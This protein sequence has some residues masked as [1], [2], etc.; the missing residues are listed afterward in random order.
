MLDIIPERNMD[1]KAEA[2]A[3]LSA[4]IEE[5]QLAPSTVGRLIAKDPNFME[6]LADPDKDITTTTLD[7]IWRFIMRKR[8]QLE[9]DLEKD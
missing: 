6:R 4:L 3:E 9:L 1:S 5:Y 8:G 2:Y 7:S